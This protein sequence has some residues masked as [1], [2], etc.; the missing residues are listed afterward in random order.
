MERD[1]PTI[2]ARRVRLVSAERLFGE[3]VIGT[4][5]WGG[6][7]PRRQVFRPLV[8]R[9]AILVRPAGSNGSWRVDVENE[10]ILPSCPPTAQGIVNVVRMHEA[11]GRECRIAAALALPADGGRAVFRRLTRPRRRCIDMFG[12]AIMFQR[13]GMTD[14]AVVDPHEHVPS[15]PA[16]YEC[17]LEL[18]DRSEFLTS[19][20]IRHRP[21][22][23]VVRPEDC[24][25]GSRESA[26]C[27]PGG[28]D[29]SRDLPRPCSIAD[30]IGH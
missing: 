28:V 22:A 10:L 23:I 15:M 26:P 5:A 20:G 24:G 7:R 14:F 17:P 2:T 1:P 12:W 11:L 18:I 13:P 19:R 21:L 16:F 25:T 8:V 4:R 27:E 30:L 9:P 29:R 3:P 6:A